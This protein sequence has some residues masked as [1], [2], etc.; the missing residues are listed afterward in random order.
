[1]DIVVKMYGATFLVRFL[2]KLENQEVYIV[3]N[4]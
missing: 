2:L 1:M 3:F 4:W